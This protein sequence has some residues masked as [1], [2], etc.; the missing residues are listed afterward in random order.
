MRKEFRKTVPFGLNKK[1]V[2]LFLKKLHLLHEQELETLKNRVKSACNKSVA[3]K[4]ELTELRER[5]KDQVKDQ[6]KEQSKVV[7]FKLI[8]PNFP[9]LALSGFWGDAD[10]FIGDDPMKRR[11]AR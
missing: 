9:K 1:S 6:V 3:L 10:R 11:K 5:V 2:D 4:T 7:N 8:E